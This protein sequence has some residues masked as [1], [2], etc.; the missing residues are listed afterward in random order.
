MKITKVQKFIKNNEAYLITNNY[1]ISYL[2]ENDE[3]LPE[4]K[5]AILLITKK[6]VY[7]FKNPLSELKI[8]KRGIS[9]NKI[10]IIVL[11]KETP[12]TKT[13]KD[14]FTLHNINNLFF[15]ESDLK[16][17]E[18]E[19]I[20]NNLRGVK[21]LK[22]NSFIESL[23]IT[24]TE[25]EIRLLKRAQTLSLKCLNKGIEF[26]KQNKL[27]HITEKDLS[28]FLLYEINKIKDCK[29]SFSP[30]VAFDKNSAI[31]HH[32]PTNKKITKGVLLIDLGVKYKGY[33][34][35][36]TRTIYFGKPDRKFIYRYNLV[37]TAKNLATNE[38]KPGKSFYDIHQLVVDYFAKY[39]VD[40][41]FIHSIGHGIGREVHEKPIVSAG[42]KLTK[43]CVITIEP[44]LYFPNKYGIRIEDMVVISE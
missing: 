35:D 16:V 2:L 33:C 23:R 22:S 43:N 17:K 18:L 24:K 40:K 44:G 28:A 9:K 34:G 14:I 41:Y 3:S 31:P 10:K 32:Y 5:T 4:E 7:I 37:K 29:E 36:I 15:E 39:K 38:A 6:E 21:F 1:N 8:G 19:T 30:V 25:E 12:L 13:L 11:S 42:D 20:K 26:I 27:K